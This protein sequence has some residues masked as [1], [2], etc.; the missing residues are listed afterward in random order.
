MEQLSILDLVKD[1]KDMEALIPKRWSCMKTCAN[2]TNELPGGGRDY[3]PGTGSPRC[4]YAYWRGYGVSGKEIKDRLI[5][6]VW[7]TWCT[8]YKPKERT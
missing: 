6:N 1:H 4:T 8:L 7:H 5:D 2:F 3:F